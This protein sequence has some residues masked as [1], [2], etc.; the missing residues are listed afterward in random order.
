M[1]LT[2]YHYN[3]KEKQG[4]EQ[5]LAST[6]LEINPGAAHMSEGELNPGCT[7]PHMSSLYPE[8]MCTILL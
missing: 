3:R 8:Q 1:H 2:A 6:S 7:F 4:Q 5:S